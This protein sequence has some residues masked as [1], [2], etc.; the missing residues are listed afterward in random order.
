MRDTKWRESTREVW[1]LSWPAIAQSLLHTL[2]FIVDRLILGRYGSAALASMQMSGPFIW[3][4]VGLMGAM[5]VGAL[6]VVG[7]E[8]GRRD[9]ASVSAAIRVSVAAALVLGVIATGVGFLVEPWIFAGFSEAGP[10]VHREA[11]AYVASMLPAMVPLLVAAMTG[12]IHQA[13]G[14]TR[15][16][17]Y[18]VGLAHAVHLPL[19]AALVFGVGGTPLGAGGA[20]LSTAIASTIEATFLVVSLLRG[21]AGVRLTFTMNGREAELVRRTLDV[22]L[23]ALAEKLAIHAGYFS[24]VFL[25]GALGAASMA[26]HQALISIE[27]ICFLSVDG[28]GVGAASLVARRLG[29]GDREGAER[30]VVV[31]L[32]MAIALL[33]TCALVFLAIP[34]PLVHAFTADPAIATVAVPVLVVA[35]VAQ[36]FMAIGAV[37]GEAFRGAGQTRVTLLVSLVC[38]FGVRVALAYWFA[39]TLGL[40]LVGIWWGSTIDWAVRSAMFGVLFRRRRF[41]ESSAAP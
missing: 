37:F 13:A 32:V 10:E 9:E 21:R 26:A 34:S 30:A 35:A 11:S 18:A 24:Y 31:A 2:V 16:P 20:G 25:I 4:L 1:A 3:T 23:P 8:V 15:T 22:A 14:D 36:P 28:F 38:G 40:G 33:S 27:S 19:G 12:A 17:L 29:A 39:F 7:R 6:A 41:R 5:Q